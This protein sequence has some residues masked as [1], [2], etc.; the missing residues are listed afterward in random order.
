MAARYLVA[1]FGDPGHAFPAIA[2]GRELRAR[3]HEVCIQTWRRWEADVVREAMLFAPAPEYHVWPGP[4]QAF[5]P[6]QAAVRAARETRPLIRDFDPDVV[7]VDILTVAASLAAELEERPWV[8][9]VP[10]LLP[11]PEPGLPPYSTGAQPPRTK[12]G[13]TLWRA[14]DPLTWAAVRRGRD[15]LNGARARVGL[16]PLADVHGG[17]SR[18]LTLVA[19]FPQLEAARTMPTWARVTGPLVWERPA[20]EDAGSAPPGEEPLVLVAPSTS[21]DPSHRLL[22]ATLAGLASEP[23]RV[24]AATNGRP[25]PAG[26]RVPRNARVLDWPSYSRTMPHCAAVVCHGGHGTVAQ[27]LAAGAPVICSPAG[28]D[29]GENAARVAWAG[30]GVSLPWRLTR[31]WS[32]RLAVRRVVGDSRY[33]KQAYEFAATARTRPG[34]STAADV[35]E[36][37]CA[38]HAGARSAAERSRDSVRHTN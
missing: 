11:T 7:V 1:A 12:V 5:T 30:A 15:E 26:V 37:L 19:T 14:V 13:R 9:L 28:G 21:Q 16:P 2:L 27:A 24:L 18:R 32:V 3:G 33:S 25:L 34:A 17:L 22:R 8:S 38:P 6:Y 10:H 36:D 35:L 31:P 20:E 4:G 29:M 23:V